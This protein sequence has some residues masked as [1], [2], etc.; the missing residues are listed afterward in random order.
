M[1]HA[2]NKY[3]IAKFIHTRWEIS[4]YFFPIAEYIDNTWI[5]ARKKLSQS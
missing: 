1:L 3:Y 2:R 5:D 4:A